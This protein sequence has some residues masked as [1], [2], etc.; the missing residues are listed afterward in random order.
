MNNR[1]MRGFTLIELLVV[2]T[3]I[4]ILAGLL[5]T[6]IPEVMRKAK[7]A[8]TSSR[9]NSI[10]AGMALVGQNEGSATFRMQQL[11]EYSTTGTAR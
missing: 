2:I 11:L 1:L 7:L 4:A 9:M 8:D 5:I 6:L 3:I 10:H